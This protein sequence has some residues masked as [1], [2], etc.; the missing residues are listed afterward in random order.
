MKKI[1][2]IL[3]ILLTFNNSA[4]AGFFG[5]I[6]KDIFGKNDESFFGEN[7]GDVNS[8]RCKVEYT[9]LDLS[10]GIEK[11]VKH[12]IQ[13]ETKFLADIENTCY[14]STQ[15]ATD[16]INNWLNK[17]KNNIIVD[18]SVINCKSR[19][20]YSNKTRLLNVVENRWDEYKSCDD[21]FNTYLI[22]WLE[23]PKQWGYNVNKERL[24]RDYEEG[25]ENFYG[26]EDFK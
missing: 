14:L 10:T 4:F 5:D 16:K 19:R 2:L 22:D 15:Y 1:F 12:T 25:F 3:F 26:E 9:Q 17:N 6:F 13:H 18:L 7:H 21:G 20:L 24:I 8:I 11:T 23:S